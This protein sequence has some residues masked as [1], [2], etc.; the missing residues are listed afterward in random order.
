[1]DVCSSLEQVAVA[2]ARTAADK[3]KVNNTKSEPNYL[4]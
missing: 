4:S 3:G 2:V 1:M